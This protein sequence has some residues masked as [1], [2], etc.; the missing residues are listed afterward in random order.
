MNFT[1]RSFY[2]GVIVAQIFLKRQKQRS[3]HIFNGRHNTLRIGWS[4]APGGVQRSG[5][6]NAHNPFFHRP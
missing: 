1:G 5:K 3:D 6:K 2:C 4:N